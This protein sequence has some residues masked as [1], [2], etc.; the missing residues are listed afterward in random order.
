MA[1]CWPRTPWR[2]LGLLPRRTQPPRI[3]RTIITSPKPR[4][5]SISIRPDNAR[6]APPD[7]GLGPS[8]LESSW[9]LKP[10]TGDLLVFGP[11]GESNE[12]SV[13]YTRTISVVLLNI[14]VKL[15]SLGSQSLSQEQQSCNYG[16]RGGRCT[17]QKTV[18][19][20]SVR[21]IRRYVTS[22]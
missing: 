16:F 7:I 8:T 17:K 21:C 14:T 3:Q 15:A 11:R 20:I 18:G 12:A 5:Q 19:A 10:P 2:H 6:T 4:L 9:P 22:R 13:R 1:N